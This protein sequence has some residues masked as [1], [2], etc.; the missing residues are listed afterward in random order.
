MNAVG[1][2]HTDTKLYDGYKFV[3]SKGSKVT[4][5]KSA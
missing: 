1:V 4:S 3:D 5:S 2:E